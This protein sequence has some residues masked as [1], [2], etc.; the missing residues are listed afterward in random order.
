V[1]Q[2][3]HIGRFPDEVDLTKRVRSALGHLTLAELEAQFAFAA[4]AL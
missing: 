2:C 1:C 3:Q 4:P